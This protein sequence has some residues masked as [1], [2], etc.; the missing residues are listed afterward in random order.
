MTPNLAS[1][2]FILVDHTQFYVPTVVVGFSSLICWVLSNS[3]CSSVLLICQPF[4]SQCL[5]DGSSLG[6]HSHLIK[7]SR[8]ATMNVCVGCRDRPFL[9]SQTLPFL[10]QYSKRRGTHPNIGPRDTN[11]NKTTLLA[12]I[13]YH[14]IIIPK[15]RQRIYRLERPSSLTLKI[16]PSKSHNR[17]IESILEKGIFAWKCS[18]MEANV[19]SDTN[20]QLWSNGPSFPLRCPY[21]QKPKRQLLVAPLQDSSSAGISDLLYIWMKNAC[22]EQQCFFLGGKEKMKYTFQ[23][24]VGLLMAPETTPPGVVFTRDWIPHDSIFA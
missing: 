10:P 22:M 13:Q 20:N 19:S 18:S 11:I 7:K 17:G 1:K 5:K 4:L 21:I 16:W 2:S 12:V 8:G 15:Y 24:L 3:F 14:F 6:A 23:Q 9:F